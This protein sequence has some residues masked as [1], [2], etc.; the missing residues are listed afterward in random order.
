MG[1]SDRRQFI[2]YNFYKVA[3][4]WRKLPQD[5]RA[6]S[7]REFAAVVEEPA[8]YMLFRSYSEKRNWCVRQTCC[9]TSEQYQR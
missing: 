5:E 1:N 8:T 7:K 2:K 6:A 9:P 4:Q 3:S